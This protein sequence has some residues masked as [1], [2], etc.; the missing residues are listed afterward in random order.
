MNHD[1]D[2]ETVNTGFVFLVLFYKD[3]NKGKTWFNNI[4]HKS[5]NPYQSFIKIRRDQPEG[6]EVTMVNWAFISEDNYIKLT[7]EANDKRT[8]VSNG[9]TDGGSL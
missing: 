9:P 2:P 7:K 3:D 5:H 8:H 1:N 4:V 6:V